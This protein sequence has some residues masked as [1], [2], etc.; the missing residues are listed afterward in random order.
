MRMYL[1]SNMYPSK[2]HL[3]Y[4]IFVK[5]FKLAVEN[6]FEIN[7][8]VLKKTTGMAKAFAYFGLY[9]KLF[10][11]S[12]TIE[13]T[14][15]IYV[16]FPLY[17]SPLLNLFL[18]KRCNIIIN[19]HGSD[20]VFDRGYKRFLAN[21]LKK[22]IRQFRIVVPSNHYKQEIIKV[23]DAQPEQ[24]FVYPSGGV[25]ATVFRPNLTQTK[26]FTIGFVSNFIDN[27]GWM[28]F[29]ECLRILA[30]EYA[31][32]YRA[33]M[34]GDG[35]SKLQIEKFIKENK[36]NVEL[37]APVA[38]SELT[39]IFS[40]LDIFIFPTKRESLGLVGLEALM[41]GIPVIASDVQGPKEY[42]IDGFNGYFFEGAEPKDL[43]NKVL[44]FAKLPIAAK[45]AMSQNAILSARPY[46]KGRG[47]QTAFKLA[48]KRGMTS[49]NNKNVYPFKNRSDFLDFIKNKHQILIALNAE[50]LIKNN[51]DLNA[52]INKNIG[53]PDGIGAVMALRRKGVNAVKIPGAEFW[54]NIIER[55]RLQKSFYFIG[56]TQ[57]V[58]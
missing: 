31:F 57:E 53:Y 16:H 48:K 43:S 56:A 12:F 22:N 24:F 8:L 11:L 18:R 47:A 4:G 29:L 55:Y 21:L 51:L 41:C 6:D 37:L 42:I 10:W 40:L 35:P 19:F 14:D 34:V 25:D 20:A 39:K 5:N 15:I 1:V 9:L 52:L 26:I 36:L 27:K 2:T 13:K 30:E 46:E 38:Q 3:R 7:L 44:K 50:K 32:S 54:L 33:L 28:V 45:T 58:Y 49:I 23:F 17:F